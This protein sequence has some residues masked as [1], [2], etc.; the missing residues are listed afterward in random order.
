M[1]AKCIFYSFIR[2]ISPYPTNKFFSLRWQKVC[3]CM[4]LCFSITVVVFFFI[5]WSL[6]IVPNKDR[7]EWYFVMNKVRRYY[8]SNVKSLNMS[9]TIYLSNYAST[10]LY[11]Q[12]TRL[13]FCGN[14]L[15][16]QQLFCNS[17]W[18][19]TN[20]GMINGKF[21]LG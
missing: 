17:L 3:N 20:V 9:T 21:T 8:L 6:C 1:H 14:I 5:L 19:S 16:P 11:V 2:N 4:V 7:H 13:I 18:K 12:I 10:F 15:G